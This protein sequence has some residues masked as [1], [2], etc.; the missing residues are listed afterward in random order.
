MKTGIALALF[1]LAACA[2]RQP[3]APET[4]GAAR[5]L[6]ADVNYLAADELEGRGTPSRGLDLAAL[7]LE[8]QLRAAGVA[9]AVDGS[10]RQSYTIGAYDPN[11][12]RVTVRINGKT[13]APADYVFVNIGRDPA[14][15]PISLALVDAGNGMVLEEKSVD[16][17]S[18]LDI[19]GKAVVA[20]KAAPW[21]LEPKSVFGPDRAIGK[22]MAATVR[23]AEMLV[24]LSEDLDTGDAEA[25]FFH[26]MKSA[27][28]AFVRQ[29][30]LTHASA[31]NPILVLKP[32]AYAPGNIEISIDTKVEEGRASNVLGRIEGSDPTLKNEWVVVSAHYDHLGSHAVPAGQDG[33]WNGAD[34]NASGTAGILEIAREMA[35]RPGK[36]SVLVFFTSGEDR[37]IFG[38]AFYS[39]KPVIAMKDVAAQINLDMIGRSHGKVE[40]LA[41]GAPALYDLAVA[42][43]KRHSIEVIPDQQP[44]WRLLYLTDLYHF[45][46]AG[47]PGIHFFTGLHADYHQPSDTAAKIRYEEMARLAALAG[48]MARVYADGAPRPGFERPKWFVTP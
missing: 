36:R 47:V 26:E 19:R 29:A 11:T 18:K 5:R 28:V 22:V 39:V 41:H 38:S 13:V 4:N 6:S 27:P 33:I 15:G 2:S 40:A 30:G 37:G 9:P 43:G 46:R 42:T 31:L 7:Y 35:R 3:A 34:D 17:L 44:T 14:K 21:P 1:L 16:D 20:R 48:E 32:K 23:G 24:Y 25:G 45:A 12:A 10:F 8:A